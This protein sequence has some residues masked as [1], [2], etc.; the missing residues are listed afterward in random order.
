MAKAPNP[1]PPHVRPAPPPPPPPPSL[2]SRSMGERLREADREWQGLRRTIVEYETNRNAMVGTSL[3]MGLARVMRA[4]SHDPAVAAR[5]INQLETQ[6]RA[7]F[8][9]QTGRL[10]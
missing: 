7:E 8:P 3:Y 4:L 1:P 2:Q 6:L 5:M 10:I 9:P